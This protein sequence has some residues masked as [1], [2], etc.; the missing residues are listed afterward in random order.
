VASIK[1][2]ALHWVSASLILHEWLL[3][4][5]YRVAID[6]LGI[7]ALPLETEVGEDSRV[8]LNQQ[9]KFRKSPLCIPATQGEDEMRTVGLIGG[10]SWESTIPYYRII[11]ETTEAVWVVSIPRK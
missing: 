6:E 4:P 5:L 11:N 1:P 10:M 3:R 2:G 8:K 7:A 9:E